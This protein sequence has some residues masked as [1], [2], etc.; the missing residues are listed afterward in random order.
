MFRRTC[1]TRSALARSRPST[2]AAM[3]SRGAVLKLTGVTVGKKVSQGSSLRR[4]SASMPTQASCSRVR[5][6]KGASSASGLAWRALRTCATQRC[7]A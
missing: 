4:E 2:V 5:G 6:L 1:T 7:N 3:T